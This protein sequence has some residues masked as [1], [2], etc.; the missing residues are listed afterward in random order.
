MIIITCVT[1]IRFCCSV[2]VSNLQIFPA[3]CFK[4]LI[5]FKSL[6][7]QSSQVSGHCDLFSN[8]GDIETVEDIGNI[9][10]G[11]LGAGLHSVLCP[12]LCNI[13][14][15]NNAGDFFYSCFLRK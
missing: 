9:G 1:N 2:H 7:S 14:K 12:V 6:L 15:T 4:V 11:E 5:K 10:D 3:C 13:T 8:L